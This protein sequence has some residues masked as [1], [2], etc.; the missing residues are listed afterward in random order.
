MLQAKL[1]PIVLRDVVVSA[2]DQ[3]RMMQN[4]NNV[5]KMKDANP[6]KEWHR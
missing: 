1:E 6:E 5:T 2:K 4:A 3:T